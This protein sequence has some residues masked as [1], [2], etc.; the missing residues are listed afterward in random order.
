MERLVS[1][2]SN[3][4]SFWYFFFHL[5]DASDWCGLNKLSAAILDSAK[6]KYLLL[7]DAIWIRDAHAI[8]V[9]SSDC[10]TPKREHLACLG[11]PSRPSESTRAPPKKPHS[12]YFRHTHT[13]THLDP[14][15]IKLLCQYTEGIAPASGCQSPKSTDWSRA[16]T[17][18]LHSH[19]TI[20]QPLLDARS[21]H[22]PF[23]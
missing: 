7:L 17:E 21:A 15:W 3:V 10:R 19:C 9:C 22:Y 5:H 14:V 2:L 8:V 20:F 11:F 6:T 12:R 1:S 16:H 4:Y 18:A 23:H 13:H